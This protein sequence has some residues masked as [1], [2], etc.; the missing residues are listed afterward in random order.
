[1]RFFVGL[2]R[3]LF[4]ALLFN[5][6]AKIKKKTRTMIRIQ[7]IFSASIETSLFIRAD[8]EATI[9]YGASINYLLL[10]L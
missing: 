8:K 5:Q 1:M 3:G 6:R 7:A 2:K 9:E 10:F 4:G